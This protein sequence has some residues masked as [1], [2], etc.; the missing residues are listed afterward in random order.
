MFVFNKEGKI[1]F[2]RYKALKINSTAH[3][4]T[5]KINKI[6]YM[7]NASFS[8]CKYEISFGN[9]RKINTFFEKIIRFL[10]LQ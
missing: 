10:G 5:S 4:F 1:I 6:K 3:E 8:E 2:R 7:F 9:Y